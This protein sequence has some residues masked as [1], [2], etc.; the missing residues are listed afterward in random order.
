MQLTIYRADCVGN[1]MQLDFCSVRI[2][3]KLHGTKDG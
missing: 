1:A 2:A 3:M